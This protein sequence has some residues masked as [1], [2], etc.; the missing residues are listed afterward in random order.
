VKELNNGRRTVHIGLFGAIVGSDTSML[1]RNA[2]GWAAG[3]IPSPILPTT[4]HTFG[5]SPPYTV[6]LMVIDDDMG[7]AWDPVLGV[8]VEVI[9]PAVISHRYITIT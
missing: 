1:L 9:P 2:I 7:W 5:N 8:P 3:G 4:T 6:D